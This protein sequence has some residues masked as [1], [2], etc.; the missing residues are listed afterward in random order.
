M[1]VG[2]KEREVKCNKFLSMLGLFTLLFLRLTIF[3]A[4]ENVAHLLGF[5]NVSDI[6]YMGN[7]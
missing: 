3:L 1:K 6:C 5:I 7:Y 4:K 2:G